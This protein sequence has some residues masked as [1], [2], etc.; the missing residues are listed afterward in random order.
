MAS[1]T[2]QARA[3][4]LSGAIL[5][6]CTGEH[7]L[8]AH[9]RAAHTSTARRPSTVQP[10]VLSRRMRRER[11]AAADHP[12]LLSCC[13]R[14][15]TSGVREAWL[16]SNTHTHTHLR[17]R[18]ANWACCAPSLTVFFSSLSPGPGSALPPPSLADP[19]PSAKA[20]RCPP[21][22][23]NTAV[24]FSTDVDC[25]R[26]RAGACVVRSSAYPPARRPRL[27]YARTPPSHLT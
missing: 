2:W 18:N 19:R 1:K 13:L 8:P 7:A 22:T 15:N 26:A 21:D 27:R 9:P 6:G 17:A 14:N 10:A 24:A 25:V 3:H 5:G 20:L 12:A 4:V 23:R 11:A 16:A